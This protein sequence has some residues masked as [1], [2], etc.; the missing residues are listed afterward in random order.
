MT[1]QPECFG[2]PIDCW[3][4]EWV[5]FIVVDVRVAWCVCLLTFLHNRALELD[6]STW[7]QSDLPQFCGMNATSEGLTVICKL[8]RAY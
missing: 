5:E 3:A 2:R 1:P 7:I 6:L 8:I 4:S